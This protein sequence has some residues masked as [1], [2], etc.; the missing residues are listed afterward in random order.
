MNPSKKSAHPAS[1]ED[2]GS[3]DWILPKLAVGTHEEARDPVLME[4]AGLKHALILCDSRLDESTLV[5]PGEV[6]QLVQR[7]GEPIRP[8]LF[9]DALAFLAERHGGDDA[10]LIACGQGRSRSVTF[11]M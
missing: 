4:W 10:V 8:E 7:D 3:M 11:A 1:R 2:N 6:R 5:L 9:D